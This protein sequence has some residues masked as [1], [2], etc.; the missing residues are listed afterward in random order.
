MSRAFSSE[1]GWTASAGINIVT[2]SGSN[3]LHGEGLFVGRPGGMQSTSFSADAQCP[4][5]R[6]DVCAADLERRSGGARA[7]RHSGLARPGVVRDRRPHREES[8]AV[9]RRGRLHAPGS[10]CGDHHAARGAG[11][12]L[13][14][15][16]PSGF[17][18]RALRSSDRFRQRAHGARQRRS[19]L[20][21]QSAGRDWRERA[22]E[23]RPAVHAARVVHSRERDRG[24]FVVH[25]E[26][27][28]I[29]LSERE[30]GDGVRPVDAVD[31]DDARRLGPVHV[32]RI[33]LRA[34]L[35]PRSRSSPTRSRG[36]R[37][38]TTCASAAASRR[39]RR[40]ATAPSSAAR[41]C[42]ASTRSTPHP[43]GRPI[44]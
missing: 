40:A 27:S 43:P 19:V 32:G 16:L 44:S 2:K 39:T 13:S 35:Q 8:H 7:A 23:R 24:H 14:R 15:A 26:R 18:R 6:V 17:A 12:D 36:R 4:S 21:H 29:R 34:R 38:S 25:A 3:A 41:S 22:A 30:S 5:S 37:T 20:R 28:A 1:F 33:A 9:L 11:D 42:S 31:A 10:D